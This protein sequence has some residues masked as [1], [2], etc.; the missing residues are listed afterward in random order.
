MTNP[1]KP[2]EA[3]PALPEF[4]L[5]VQPARAKPRKL[6]MTWSAEAS[7]ELR[8]LFGARLAEGDYCLHEPSG[9]IVRVETVRAYSGEMVES[10]AESRPHEMTNNVRDILTDEPF[11]C[12]E[13]SLGDP[14]TPLEVLAYQAR[15]EGK[16]S[17]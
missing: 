3:N 16:S 17:S 10:A 12:T 7:H 1:E 5:S 4:D 2:A 13:S 11:I 15:D 14:L 6:K 9:R 8:N